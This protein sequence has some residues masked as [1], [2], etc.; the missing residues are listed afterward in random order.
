MSL[1]VSVALFSFHFS[2]RFLVSRDFSRFLLQDTFFQSGGMAQPVWSSFR[3]R[4]DRALDSRLARFIRL[5]QSSR[6][7][8]QGTSAPHLFLPVMN[9]VT[10]AADR[11]RVKYNFTRPSRKSNDLVSGLLY[12]AMCSPYNLWANT[13]RCLNLSQFAGRWGSWYL[14]R[15][16]CPCF[17]RI[18]QAWKEGFSLKG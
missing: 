7:F 12:Q 15:P 2:V 8:A 5:A 6:H 17:R 13:L 16:R 9:L 1:F 14:A 11:G 4:A 3:A 10:C 18:L